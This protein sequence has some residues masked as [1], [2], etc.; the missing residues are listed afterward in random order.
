MSWKFVFD[1]NRRGL[2][3]KNQFAAA[4]YALKGGYRFLAWN[5]LIFFLREAPGLQ[6]PVGGGIECIDVGIK[7]SDCF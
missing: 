4:D 1:S 2:L 3:W 7:V 5:G 6:S